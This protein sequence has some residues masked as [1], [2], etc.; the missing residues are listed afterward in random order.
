MVG[1]WVGLGYGE[2]KVKKYERVWGGGLVRV[3]ESPHLGM[4]KAGACGPHVD[5]GL[6]LGPE[7][8]HVICD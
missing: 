6:R 1:G 7:G 4:S 3:G 8:S 5:R 2:V